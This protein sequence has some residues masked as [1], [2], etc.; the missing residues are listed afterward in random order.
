MCFCENST[1]ILDTLKLVENDSNE[2]PSSRNETLA[3]RSNTE[4][5][6]VPLFVHILE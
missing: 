2:K 1:A 3:L 4:M 6:D 5:L